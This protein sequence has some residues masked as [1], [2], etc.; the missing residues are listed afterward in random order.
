MLCKDNF[1][2]IYDHLLEQLLH[3]PEYITSPRGQ[4]IHE[5]MNVMFRIE[6]PLYNSF[7]NKIRCPSEKYLAKELDLYFR[8]VNSAD[9][10]VKASKFWKQIANEDGTVNSAYGHLIFKRFNE[11]GFNQWGWA[12]KCLTD[13]ADTRQAFMHFNTP[14][15][16]FYGN[17]DQVCT[18]N[19]IFNIRDNKL[20]A[21]V[22][23]RSSDIY[24][25]LVY[26]I[27][28]F[29]YLQQ[30]MFL[31]LKPHYPKLELGSY[32]HH[33]V[34]LHLYERNIKELKEAHKYF[35]P[36]E[37]LPPLENSPI[38]KFGQFVGYTG[39]F[40]EWMVQYLYEG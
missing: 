37:M 25:G 33:S 12:Y 7:I 4:K 6:N 34:S 9:E 5:I 19:Y 39:K 23:M 24:F 27:P 29:T 22:M 31:L 15:H 11:H 14:E 32:T 18:L 20:N 35:C 3:R 2:E 16:Q 26:D 8:G 1:A 36:K 28:F 17:K 30:A 38:D 21:T 10:F 40:Q 13:D